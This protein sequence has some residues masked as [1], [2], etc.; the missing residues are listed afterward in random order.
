MSRVRIRKHEAVP[1][2]GSYEV[3]FP[4]GNR[5]FYFEDLAGRRLRSEQLTR[6]RALEQAKEL[7]R[8][9]R[10]KVRP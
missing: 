8:T 5:Y 2:C 4:G 9:E 7:V 1:G 6:D 3:I 10:D